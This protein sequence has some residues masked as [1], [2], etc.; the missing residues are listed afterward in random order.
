MRRDFPLLPVDQAY[1]EA[2]GLEWETVVHNRIQWVLIPG[3]VLPTG[4]NTAKA[5]AALRLDLTYPDSQI[6]MVFFYPHLVRTDGKGIPNLEGRVT[7]EDREFQQWSRHRT[8]E[9]PWRPGVDDLGTHME[10]VQDWLLR[11]FERP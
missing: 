10:L 8:A 5:T 7:I 3:Y 6:D 1:L 4:Y 11:E 2:S 9:N